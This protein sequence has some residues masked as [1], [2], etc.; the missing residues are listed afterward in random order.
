MRINKEFEGLNLT[1][2]LFVWDHY[3][4]ISAYDFNELY[5]GH[6]KS[7]NKFYHEKSEIWYVPGIMSGSDYGGDTVT[8]ANYL[9]MLPYVKRSKFVKEVY[10]GYSSYG[11]AFNVSRLKGKFADELVSIFRGLETYPLIDDEELGK[12]EIKLEWENWENN[13]E[14]DFKRELK[15]LLEKIGIVV[16]DIEDNPGVHAY[17]LYDLYRDLMEKTNT[18]VRFET[19]CSVYI[20]LDELFEDPKLTFDLI[21]EN[22]MWKWLFKFDN[23]LDEI[24][25]RL[26]YPNATYPV[27]LEALISKWGD[28]EEIDK[29]LTLYDEIYT[30]WTCNALS[31]DDREALAT[32]ANESV[33]MTGKYYWLYSVLKEMEK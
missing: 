31:F 24:V 32:V 11:L 23:S 5:L 19:G 1:D 2:D 28:L 14:S 30:E 7:Y 9:A 25:S 16:D 4:D 29:K 10:G 6:L 13:L 8:R 21:L 15:K 17:N 20:D 22:E 3:D 18:E 33:G 27:T 26:R 12:L